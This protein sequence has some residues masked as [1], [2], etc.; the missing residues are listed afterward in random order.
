MWNNNFYPYYNSGMKLSGLRK[1]SF[2]SMLDKTQK[3]LNVI[4]QAIPV[5]YQI[6]PLYDNAKTALKV[7]S[8]IKDEPSSKEK[9]KS[10]KKEESIK[11]K[12]KEKVKEKEE[13]LTQTKKER[14]SNSPTYF[15]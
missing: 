10:P 1:L 8:A 14:L 6:K 12:T 7:M 4:N 3:T 9:I 5:F 11:E 13:I 2:A 15:L